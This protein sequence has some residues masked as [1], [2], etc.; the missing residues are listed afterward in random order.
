MINVAIMIVTMNDGGI[1]MIIGDKIKRA[2]KAKGMS[3]EELGDILGVSK[4]SICG[5]EMGTRTP[6]MEKFIKLVD[7]L[8]LSTDTLLGR[9]LNVICEDTEPYT[10]KIAKVDLE[11]IKE[12]RNY[13]LLYNKICSSPKRTIDL[14]N[15]KMK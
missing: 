10:T 8:D 9:D 15:R 12:L 2:R 1:V 14:I 4:V 11:I 3:Q 7:T 5:Y 6:N 13:P